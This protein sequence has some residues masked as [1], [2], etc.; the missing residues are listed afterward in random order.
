MLPERAGKE[1]SGQA[2][3]ALGLA[4]LQARSGQTS[5][6]GPVS[7]LGWQE[8]HRVTDNREERTI[9]GH[10]AHHA[11]T[12]CP[13]LSSS[14]TMKT[15]SWPVPSLHYHDKAYRDPSYSGSRPF[16]GLSNTK[17][18]CHFPRRL[19]PPSWRADQGPPPSP[20]S[21]QAATCLSLPRHPWPTAQ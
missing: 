18:G 16:S 15:S 19:M 3:L 13:E 12:G 6:E 21:P 11:K 4:V 1:R 10:H 14:R 9:K 2:S 5:R 8:Q 20:P 17:T 7:T